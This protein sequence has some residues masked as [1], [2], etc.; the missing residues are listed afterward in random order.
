MGKYIG[1]L[2]AVEKETVTEEQNIEEL[3]LTPE[4]RDLILSERIKAQQESQQL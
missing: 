2:G 4:E 3:I 1:I